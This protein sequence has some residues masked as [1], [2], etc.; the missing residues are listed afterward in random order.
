MARHSGAPAGKSTKSVGLCA[1]SG[2]IIAGITGLAKSVPYRR[3]PTML[4]RSRSFHFRFAALPH[5]LRRA[6]AIVVLATSLPR[7]A[8]A[9][10]RNPSAVGNLQQDSSHGGQVFVQ[11]AVEADAA[12]AW[13]NASSLFY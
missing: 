2:V 11:N 4:L 8:L 5:S 10:T 1:R 13:L 3:S 9:L 7:L 6:V 12:F